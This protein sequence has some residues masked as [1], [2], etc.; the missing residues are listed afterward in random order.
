VSSGGPLP[1]G[2]RGV[3]RVVL[4][5]PIIARAGDRFVLRRESPAATVGGG[6]V[7]DPLPPRRRARRWNANPSSAAERLALLLDEAG[8]QGLETDTLYLRLGVRQPDVLTF[9]RQVAGAVLV[10]NHVFSEEAVAKAATAVQAAVDALRPSAEERRVRIESVLDAT[11]LV[12]GDAERLQ[13]IAANLVSNAVKFTPPGGLVTVQVRAASDLAELIVTDTGPGISSD[14]LPHVFEWFR[15]GDAEQTQRH[16]GLGL[17]LGIV[18]QLAELHGGHVAVESPLGRGATFLVT[19]PLADSDAA[20]ASLERSHGPVLPHLQEGPGN[21]G[22][23][24]GV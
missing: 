17:G 24:G 7:T 13:Q 16:S 22:A 21:L 4:Q 2:G 20:L 23:A 18:R 15:Q 9:T 10:G 8:A 3:A 6:T 19:L 14:L 12:Q 5:R 11:V 1:P